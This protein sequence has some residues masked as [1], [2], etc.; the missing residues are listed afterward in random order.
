MGRAGG[1]LGRAQALLIVAP[2]GTELTCTGEMPSLA[3]S[4]QGM[5]SEMTPETREAL[6]KPS[7]D[8][9]GLPSFGDP[10][11]R[12]SRIQHLGPG[13]HSPSSSRIT[14]KTRVDEG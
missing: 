3:G 7:P 9:H 5:R 11:N 10:Q 8:L 13:C 4:Q 14:I 1:F 12:F 2:R 6:T